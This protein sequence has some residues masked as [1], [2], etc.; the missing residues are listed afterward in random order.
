VHRA[1]S[2][3]AAERPHFTVNPAEGANIAE[4]FFKAS[5]RK[6][7]CCTRMVAAASLLRLM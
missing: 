1:R 3:V 7:F 6:R 4:A 5:S 2:H